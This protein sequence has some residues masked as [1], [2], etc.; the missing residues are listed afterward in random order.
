MCPSLDIRDSEINNLE[1]N[2]SIKLDKKVDK[3]LSGTSGK[4]KKGRTASSKGKRL[5]QS[6]KEPKNLDRPP[7]KV[8]SQDE[9]KVGE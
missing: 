9:L 2:N 4:T 3:L 8:K 6:L 1:I 7:S 5:V